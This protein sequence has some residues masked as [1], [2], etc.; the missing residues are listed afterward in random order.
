[1]TASFFLFSCQ[2]LGG[3]VGYLAG[4]RLGVDGGL[5]FWLVL[6]DRLPRFGRAAGDL[7]DGRISCGGRRIG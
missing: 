3:F 1:V 2:L 5:L 6:I 7:G 4:T